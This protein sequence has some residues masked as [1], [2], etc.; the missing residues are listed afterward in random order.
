MYFR[1]LESTLWAPICKFS[2]IGVL[3]KKVQ[4]YN[5]APKAREAWFEFLRQPRKKRG[6]SDSLMNFPCSSFEAGQHVLK[7]GGHIVRDLAY[8]RL[9]VDL[10]L[11]GRMCSNARYEDNSYLTFFHLLAVIVFE[12][13]CGGIAKHTRTR[14]RIHWSENIPSH[15]AR[16][17][18][19]WK[20]SLEKSLGVLLL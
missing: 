11:Q 12:K 10:A 16:R 2:K 13:M 14:T 18:I 1:M 9:G 15:M 5:C 17:R 3:A 7:L 4:L 8:W 6:L 20:K 19:I